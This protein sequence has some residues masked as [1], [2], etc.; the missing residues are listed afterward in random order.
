MSAFVRGGVVRAVA[1]IRGGAEAA[2]RLVTG[3]GL[4]GRRGGHPGECCGGDEGCEE[5]RERHG[6][7]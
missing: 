3:E 2:H 1:Q 5:E 7:G 4:A 6:R